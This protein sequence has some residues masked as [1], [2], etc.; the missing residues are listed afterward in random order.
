MQREFPSRVSSPP[1]LCI[2]V[3]WSQPIMNV[4]ILLYST[5]LMIVRDS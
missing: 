4:P 3:C 1:A 5:R 2:R